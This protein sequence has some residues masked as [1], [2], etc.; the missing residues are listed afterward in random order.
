MQKSYTLRKNK[1]TS[2]WF[3]LKWVCFYTLLNMHGVDINQFA[4]LDVGV[5]F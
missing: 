2:E 1:P 3:S 4:R 5:A